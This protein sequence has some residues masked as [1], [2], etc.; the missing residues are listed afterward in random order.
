MARASAAL[1]EF[2]H[3]VNAIRMRVTGSGSLKMQLNSLDDEEIQVLIPF[4]MTSTTRI[5]PT[6]LA[7]FKSQ[8][9]QLEIKTTELDEQIDHIHRILIFAKPVESSYP[10]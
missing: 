10:G 7:N 3:H 5:E 9:I 4:T 8:R 2:I 1:G 6:R